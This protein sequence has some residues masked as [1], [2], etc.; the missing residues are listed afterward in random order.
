MGFS[1]SHCS[2]IFIEC[3]LLTLSLFLLINFDASKSPYEYVHSVRIE[4]PNL[5]LAGT[6]ITYKAT[7]DA[8]T[9]VIQ[10]FAVYT[11]W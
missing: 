2:S 11:V 9:S 4:L 10:H 3:C 8:D 5:I 6:R 7:G 1:I